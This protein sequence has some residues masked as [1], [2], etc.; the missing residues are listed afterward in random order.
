MHHPIQRV[1]LFAEDVCLDRD[2]REGQEGKS[3]NVANHDVV[4][5]SRCEV[6]LLSLELMSGSVMSEFVTGE[7]FE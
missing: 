5:E 2:R 4:G 7:W 1:L 6:L 3:S